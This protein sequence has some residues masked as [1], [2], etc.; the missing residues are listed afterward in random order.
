MPRL[1]AKFFVTPVYPYGKDRYYHEIVALAEGFQELGHRVIGNVNYWQIPEVSSYLIP[2]DDESDFDI[3]VYDYRYV[4]S[5]AHLL[6]RH[7]YPNFRKDRPHILLDRN[8]WISP[9]WLDKPYERFELIASGNLYR[10]VKYRRNMRPWA[11]G[12]T[13]RIMRAIDRFY[14]EDEPQDPV[15]GSNSRT[16][17]NVRS[18]LHAALSEQSKCYP[19]KPCLSSGHAGWKA[20]A[21]DPDYIYWKQTTERH[22]PD[23]FHALNRHLLFSAICGYFEYRP[24]LYQPYSFLDKIRRRPFIWGSKIANGL[25]LDEASKQFLFQH[26]SFR[27]Y[28][29]LYSRA[30]PIQIDLQDWNFWMP[31]MPADGA[32]YLGIKRFDVRGLADRLAGMSP[33]EI[34]EIG[35]KG[36]MFAKDHYSP[37][38][39]AARLLEYLKETTS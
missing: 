3:A 16:D 33:Q 23:Y 30:C 32:H 34:S 36:R 25:G 27:F 4:T 12:L 8:D 15:I 13:S 18:R 26:D 2:E 22:D 6:F 5:F 28:E 38:A 11:M 29:V 7:G 1:T 21:K 19:L 24:L 9:I 20:D 31:A 10:N 14:K 39:Q 35:R 17:N 37:A